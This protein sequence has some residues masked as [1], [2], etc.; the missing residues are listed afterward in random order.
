MLKVINVIYLWCVIYLQF[1][2]V[3][4]INCFSTFIVL[5]LHPPEKWQI[6]VSL[7]TQNLWWNSP[8]SQFKAS[9]P[10][11]MHRCEVKDR[12]TTF[13][14]GILFHVVKN[15]DLGED[16]MKPQLITNFFIYLWFIEWHWPSLML[17]TGLT[18]EGMLIGCIELINV[19]RCYLNIFGCKS[20]PTNGA[21]NKLCVLFNATVLHI[22]NHCDVIH[23][24][25]IILK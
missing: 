8:L 4:Q 9:V 10:Q 21:W 24:G 12:H 17:N 15:A 1:V 14:E 19:R 11:F 5:F 6:K 16:L 2:I 18:H 7:H 25:S 3:S 13:T 20:I 22:I 23:W